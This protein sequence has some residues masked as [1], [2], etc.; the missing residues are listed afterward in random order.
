MSILLQKE[1]LQGKAVFLKTIRTIPTKSLKKGINIITITRSGS[2]R[3][4]AGDK[5]W[6]RT[7]S[8]I[9]SSQ[10]IMDF[11]PFSGK[12]YLEMVCSPRE[13]N[14]SE[15]QKSNASPFMV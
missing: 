12:V 10:P 6:S 2:A 15:R 5:H 13:A 14:L 4:G 11:I 8:W 1:I 3:H 7:T 9:F